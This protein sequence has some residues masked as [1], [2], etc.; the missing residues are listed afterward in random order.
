MNKELSLL[1]T[2]ICLQLM[3]DSSVCLKQITGLCEMNEYAPTLYKTFCCSS[4]LILLS[5][6][7]L[8]LPR[9]LRSA[10]SKTHLSSQLF[11]VVHGFMPQNKTAETETSTAGNWRLLLLFLAEPILSW[12]IVACRTNVMRLWRIECYSFKCISTIS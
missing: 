2:I 1:R 5:S 9:F 3:I 7:L 8:W 12:Y 10:P 6:L 11:K 4:F